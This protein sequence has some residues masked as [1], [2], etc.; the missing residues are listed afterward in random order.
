MGKE[1]SALLGILAGTAIGATLGILFAPDKGTTTR[2]RIADE[3]AHTKDMLSEKATH[4]RDNVVTTM[5]SKKHTLDEKVENIVSD[6]SHKA[7]DVITTLERKL[8]ELKA[9][10]K[11]LQKD[12]NLSNAAK[13]NV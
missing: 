8:S 7:E 2:Q 12:S 11:N 9:K 1:S 10:N 13:I 5:S 4:L 3:A 6:A